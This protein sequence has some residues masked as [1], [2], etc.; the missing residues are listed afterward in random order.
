MSLLSSRLR[1]AVLVALATPLAACSSNSEANPLATGSSTDSALGDGTLGP[2][3][4]DVSIDAS[5]A[6]DVHLVDTSPADPACLP[7]FNYDIS[8]DCTYVYTYPC[9]F[10][11]GVPL[12]FLDS[13]D[14][15]NVCP[16]AEGGVPFLCNTGLVEP[17]AEVGVPSGDAP[18][19]TAA[20]TGSESSADSGTDAISSD[21]SPSDAGLVARLACTHCATGRRPPG[22]VREREKQMPHAPAAGVLFA[23]VAELEAASIA[24]FATLGRELRTHGA[25]RRLLDEVARAKRDEVRHA[26]AMGRLARRLGG[27][28][29]IPHVR[30]I[31]PRDLATL[32]VDNAVEGCVRETFGAAVALFQAERAREPRMRAVLRRIAA[33]ETRH[34]EVSARIAGWTRRRLGAEAHRR[35]D[36]SERAAI[37]SLRSEIVAG[38]TPAGLRD[39][40]GLPSRAAALRLF[41]ALFAETANDSQGKRA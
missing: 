18:D 26:M 19:A 4:A 5:D 30:S 20:D 1:R 40:S 7:V 24:A 34:A 17:E 9:G 25:P 2:H 39:L 32:A 21:V 11:D 15:V 31:A 12:G 37:A 28:P 29:R 22:L 41:D 27:C 38:E 36:E 3:D 16:P 14:C 33:D 13:L 23:Q 10:P 6:S 35:I 8:D